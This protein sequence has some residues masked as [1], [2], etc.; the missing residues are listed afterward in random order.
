MDL[1]KQVIPTIKDY[2]ALEIDLKEIMK[3]IDSVPVE[4]RRTPQYQLVQGL[5]KK[6]EGDAEAAYSY[7][8]KALALDGGFL[9]ARREISKMG[10]GAKSK[11]GSAMDLLTGDITATIS[12]LFK[13]KAD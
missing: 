11:T 5:I 8:D 2:D 1:E 13:K 10:S 6:A 3:L 12:S 7:F 9:E 4:D